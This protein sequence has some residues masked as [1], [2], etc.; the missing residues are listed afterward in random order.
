MA[1]NRVPI[2]F[3]MG[4][5]PDEHAEL[6]FHMVSSDY[7]RELLEEPDPYDPM[8]LT[9]FGRMSQSREQRGRAGFHPFSR[10]KGGYPTLR[11]L[12]RQDLR[13]RRN[14]WRVLQRRGEVR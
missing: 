9:A 6:P 4:Y 11:Q 5:G 14:I 8:K 3:N 12:Q 2:T 13:F 10:R 1:N 7:L